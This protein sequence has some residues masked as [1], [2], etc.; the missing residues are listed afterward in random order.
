MDDVQAGVPSGDA[1]APVDAPQSQQQAPMKFK[2]PIDGSEVE[3]DLEEL[4]RGYSH[5]RAANKRMQEAAQIR[6]AEEA[7]RA[8]AKAGEFDW[9]NEFA[10]DEEKVIRWAEK[11][12]LSKMEYDALPE[13]EKQLRA[14]KARA[15]KLEKQLE[16]LTAK[17]RQQVEQQILEKAYAEVDAEIAEALESFKGKKTPRLVRRVAEAM[18]ANLEKN[19]TPLPSKKALEVAQRSLQEDVQEYLNVTPMS[20]LIKSLSKDQMNALRQV[21]VQEAKSQAPVARQSFARDRE[22]PERD[23]N[24]LTT[25]E[26]FKKLENKFNR[27]RG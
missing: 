7:R 1:G 25:D 3:V 21:F 8:K 4:K 6:K 11:K 26:Y 14:E 22:T 18:Y 17:E 10:E 15:E 5:A 2:I 24:A 27:K 9:L 13:A 23:K 16:E 20:E 12:L 19:Q